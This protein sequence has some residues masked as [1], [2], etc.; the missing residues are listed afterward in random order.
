MV[1]IVRAFESRDLDAVVALSLRAWAPVHASLET[2]LRDSEVYSRLHP[3]WRADQEQAVREACATEGMRVWIAEVDS[4][5]T[6][7]VAAILH[8]PKAIGE[9]HMI[10][11][12]PAYQ[13]D[14][15]GSRLMSIAI[16]WFR[17]NGMTVA[18]VDT[19]GDPGHAPARRTYERAGFTCLPVARYLKAL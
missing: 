4:S 9:V 2:V 18:M 7:F 19:G 17:E 14:G 1:P 8:H 5:V 15:I 11:V 3:D 10:A 6:G 12:D 16:E 13:A